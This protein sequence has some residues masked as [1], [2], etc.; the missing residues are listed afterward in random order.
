MHASRARRSGALVITAG[1][2]FG[3]SACAISADGASSGSGDDQTL[4]F[5]SYYQGTQADW[6]QKQADVFE[7]NNPGVTVDIVETVGDQQDQK[8]LASVATGDTPD[9]FINNIVVDYPTLVAGGVTADLTEY[10]EGF[11]DKD[12]FAESAAWS[13]DD[14]VYNLLPFTNLIGL[15]YNQ[16]ILTEVGIDAPPTTLDELQAD[17]EAVKAHGQYQGIA[18]SGAPTVEGAW[19]FAP[20]LLGLGIDY[21]NF[22]GPEVEAA[23]QR[24]ETWAKAGYTPQATATWDQNDSWQ[25][26]ATGDYAFGINGN[27]QLGNAAEA[28]FAWGT[29]QYPAPA[30]GESIVYPGGEGF[31]IGANSDKK[32][33]AWKFLEE[34]V[35]TPEAGESIFEIAGSIPVRADVAELPAIKENVAV[36]PFVAAAQTSGSWPKNE[37]TANI[38][39]ALGEAVS[40]VISGQTTAA[41]ASA[42]AIADIA[43]AIEDGGGGCS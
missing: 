24:A 6:L 37:N 5:W 11:A 42:T 17:L 23:F 32:D 36:Q 20:E 31:G 2:A 41:D 30:G 12:Q 26:F 15:Y 3:L 27:W 22:E 16:D 13:T 21:C 14:K 35:L 28:S 39:K 10:W 8:L 7:K 19:L 9:L 34:A 29:T 18:L 40:S 43:A 33:L 25:Q 4:T 38:Q 1:L